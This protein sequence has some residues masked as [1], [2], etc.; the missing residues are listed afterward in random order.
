MTRTVGAMLS[1]MVEPSAYG[2]AGPAEDTIME[3]LTGIAGQS[4]GAWG[5][6]GVTLELTGEANDYVG[7]GLSGGKII[8][9]PHDKIGFKRRPPSSPA[10]R[11]LWRH[12]RRVLPA[13]RGGR[14][15][16]RAQLR[17]G[18]RRRKRGATTAANT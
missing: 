1:A 15:F 11:S 13:R 2:H 17:C 5:A 12:H 14:A 3:K 8:V 9:N 7:K 10:T 18:G 16:R 4:I 6:K